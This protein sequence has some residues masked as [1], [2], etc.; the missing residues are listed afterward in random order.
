MWREERTELRA[1][2][3]SFMCTWSERK[4]SPWEEAQVQE[5]GWPRNGDDGERGPFT[6]RQG[7]RETARDH[8]KVSSLLKA[9]QY[10]GVTERKNSDSVN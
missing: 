1:W 8:E 6:S 4:G 7:R 2:R 10:S 3:K 5:P 9:D